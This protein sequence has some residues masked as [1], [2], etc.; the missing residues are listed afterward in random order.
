MNRI[1]KIIHQVWSGIDEPLPKHFEKLGES[2]KSD[3]PEWEYIV[4]DNQK[5][6]DFILSNYPEYWES[7]QAFPYNVQRW[8]VIRYLILDKIGGMYVDFDYQSLARM[9][10]LLEN[11]TCCFSEEENYINK[12]GEKVS[13]FNNALML[14]V[15]KHPFMQKI[16][17]TAFSDKMVY[18]NPEPKQQCVL[19]T[20]GPG[21]ITTLYNSLLSE[22]KENVYII[23]AKYVTPF[24]VLQARFVRQGYNGPEVKKA[25]EEAY[26]VHYFWVGWL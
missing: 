18:A 14:S 2:W 19:S 24:S 11:K 9:D 15:P 17:E 6:N 21:M 7:Y 10:S 1:P 13:V 3:Y 16:I 25:L 8:D 22:E 4:W 23:P 5:M 26:A 20:T 12:K